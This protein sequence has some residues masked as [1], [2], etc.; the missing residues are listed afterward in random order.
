MSIQKSFRRYLKKLTGSQIREIEAVRE[1]M[2]EIHIVTLDQVNDCITFESPNKE[3]KIKVHGDTEMQRVYELLK[4]INVNTPEWRKVIRSIRSIESHALNEHAHGVADNIQASSDLPKTAEKLLYIILP[5]SAREHLPGDLEEEYRTTILP[6]FG[7]RY[8]K[9]WY[10]KQ[11]VGSI[12]PILRSQLL[13]LM[14][15]ASVAKVAQWVSQRF[16]F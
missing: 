9:I 3:M 10:W 2:Q 12:G 7:L 13:K 8:A 14:G 11:V 6:K 5:K 16:G 15:F 1:F 4:T